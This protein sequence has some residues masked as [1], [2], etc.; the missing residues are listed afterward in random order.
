MGS[1]HLSSILAT[2]IAIL[3]GIVAA[4][5]LSTSTQISE[6]ER[7]ARSALREATAYSQSLD[8]LE[9]ILVDAESAQRGYLLTGDRDYLKPYL[10]AID[11]LEAHSD[12][13][14]SHP[15]LQSDE[16][17][18]LRNRVR[19]KLNELAQTIRLF[20]EGSNQ[21]AL[22]VVQT[23]RGLELMADIRRIIADRQADVSAEA[24][25]ASRRA[26]YYNERSNYVSSLLMILLGLAAMMGLFALYQWFRISRAETVAD[27]ATDSAERI[28][29]IAH[30]LDHRMKNMFAIAQGMLRQSARNAG[31]EVKSFS[32][33]AVS[34]LQ[35]MSHA[36]SATAELE[37]IRVL[38]VCEIVERVVRAQ[39]LEDHRFDVEGEDIDVPE[40]SISPL[41][42]ILHELTTNAL[43]YGAWRYDNE[44]NDL[45]NV[46]L[47][48]NTTEEGRFELLWDER[49][50]ARE[51]IEPKRSGYGSRLIKACAAQLGGTVEYDWHDAGVKIRLDADASRLGTMM[52]SSA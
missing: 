50:H 2:V 31:E 47:S 19:L 51:D 40:K 21:A 30:E 45:S 36:Y 43:K 5:A 14:W 3:T 48:W 49:H 42:L 4:V 29:I 46:R 13:G 22:S 35:A 20:D 8:Q 52:P 10:D 6:A 15:A 37:D 11:Y 16:E 1:T 41:S 9:N 24:E 38:P 28:E 33:D 17:G 44:A 34:R 26:R 18:V 27:E 25:A 39:L 32:E 7:E 12:E 23:D